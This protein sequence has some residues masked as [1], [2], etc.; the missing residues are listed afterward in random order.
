[1]GEAIL[2]AMFTALTSYRIAGSSAVTIIIL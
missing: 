2:K 1:V